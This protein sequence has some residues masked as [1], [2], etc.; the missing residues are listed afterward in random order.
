V[1]KAIIEVV[2]KRVTREDVSNMKDLGDEDRRLACAALGRSIGRVAAER[3]TAK[4]DAVLSSGLLNTAIPTGL[5]EEYRRR[6]DAAF[7]A[8]KKSIESDQIPSLES[9]RA[10]IAELAR[11]AR[12]RNREIAGD[13]SRGRTQN[14]RHDSDM[15]SD[16][17]DTLSCGGR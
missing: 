9:V 10:E 3:T 14:Q 16:C 5:R 11:M 4:M 15:K 13:I 8:L 1:N 12:E 2:K 17:V 7:E 6:G